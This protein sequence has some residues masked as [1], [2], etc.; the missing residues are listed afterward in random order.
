MADYVAKEFFVYTAALSSLAA[1]TSQAVQVNVEADSDF[2][3][4]KI[5]QYCT[6]TSATGTVLANPNLTV[7]ITDSASGRTIF[8]SAQPISSIAGSGELPFV[9]PVAKLLRAKS[10]LTVTFANRTA[11]TI[12]NIALS[13]AGTKL[14]LA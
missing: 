4:N 7:Q 8:D 12:Y 3:I 5:M 11:A 10:T 1:G 6:D 2:M 14:Y 9:P 13:F